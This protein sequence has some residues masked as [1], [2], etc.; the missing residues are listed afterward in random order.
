VQREST[1]LCLKTNHSFTVTYGWVPIDNGHVSYNDNML[2]DMILSMIIVLLW[3]K[4]SVN[5]RIHSK[6]SISFPYFVK[7]NFKKI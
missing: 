5:S 6:I 4:F 2:V 1:L 7:R 3:L